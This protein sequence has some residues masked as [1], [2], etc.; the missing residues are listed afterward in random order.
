MQ[1]RN[2]TN[3]DEA[4]L[5]NLRNDGYTYKEISEIIDRS[6][7]SISNK[8]QYMMK[9]GSLNPHLKSD[10]DPDVSVS[11][12]KFEHV[13]D[14]DNINIRSV[15][16]RIRTVEQAI[17]HAAINTTVWMVDKVNINSWEAPSKEHGVT[18]LWQ[19]KVWLKRRASKPI[20]DGLDI[21]Y[22]R[23]LAYKP[24]VP[25]RNRKPITDDKHM[26]EISLFDSHFGKLAW[27]PESDSEYNIEI[28]ENIYSNAVTDLLDRVSGYNVE[29]ILFPVGN[30]FFHV[31][32]WILTTARGTPQDHDGRF[33]KIFEIGSMA[34]IKSIDRCLSMAP[35]EIIWVPGNH[36]PET[37][38]YLVRFVDA[39]YRN[40]NDVVID[41]SPQFRKYMKY[42]ANL[43]G[44]THGNEEPHRDLPAIMA[45]EVPTMWANSQCRAWHLGHTHK[46]S[47]IVHNIEDTYG[48]VTVSVLPSLSGTDSWHYKKGYVKNNRAAE[49]YLWNHDD[50]YAG[51]FSVNARFG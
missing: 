21:L 13:E 39:W 12:E 16:E 32:N 36:D 25:K 49:A 10:K 43:I 30:D 18:K 11:H 19:V 37:S 47:K 6:E 31:N 40:I 9:N 4:L 22:K 34:I 42:G 7:S 46:K 38:W 48:G 8:F 50:G 20:T 29:K 51:H 24:E 5:L 26:L 15:S 1:R 2:W 35:V 44:F 14:D 45:A 28:A 17:E 33:Q 23:I 3:E 27:G 41:K